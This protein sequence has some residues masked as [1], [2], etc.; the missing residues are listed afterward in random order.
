MAW[1]KS[2]AKRVM[3]FGKKYSLPELSLMAT[4]KKPKAV[5]RVAGKP[6]IAD[7][8]AKAY[9]R[10]AS[11]YIEHLSNPKRWDKTTFKQKFNV[12]IEDSL[13]HAQNLQIN[14]GKVDTFMGRKSIGG[15]VGTPLP[16][17]TPPPPSNPIEMVLDRP[18]LT[19][20]QNSNR[21]QVETIQNPVSSSLIT[22]MK[23]YVDFAPGDVSILNNND[24]FMA[25]I[26]A[27]LSF[28]NGDKQIVSSELYDIRDSDVPIQFMEMYGMGSFVSETAVIDIYGKFDYTEQKM[29]F[30]NVSKI[31]S[32]WIRFYKD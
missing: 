9:T 11:Q 21:A 17:P 29:K 3:S 32:I 14:I 25:R 20:Y 23:S 8:T 31:E 22:I 24:I 5:K 16:P 6:N 26:F 19:F 18:Y 7:S 10:L 4:L 1:S 13:P 15:G 28:Q 12:P 27:K 30:L 2:S